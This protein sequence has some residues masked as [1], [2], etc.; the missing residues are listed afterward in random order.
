MRLFKVLVMLFMLSVSNAQ[1]NEVLTFLN[2]LNENQLSKT[3]L[4]FD[5]TSRETWHFLPGTMYKRHGIALYD[6]DETQKTHAFNLL[7]HHLSSTGYLKT[8]KIIELERYLGELSGNKVFRDP[9][10]YYFA[11]YGNPKKDSLWSWSFEGHHISLNFTVSNEK[12]SASPRFMGT[13]PAEIKEGPLKGQ[14]VLNKEEDLAFELINSM[15]E[16]QRAKTIF[17]SIA[18]PDI[19]TSNKSKVAPLEDEGIKAKNLNEKQKAILTKLIKEYLLTLPQELAKER[20]RAI[21]IAE[22]DDIRFAWAGS[23]DLTKGHYYRIQGDTF[24]IEFDNTQNNANHVHLV[25][26]EF[27]ADFGRDLIKEHY[28]KSDHHK[29]K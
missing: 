5:N 29:Q 7:K 14:R 9:E 27:N 13:N 19:L 3:I 2:T 16:E 15:G 22:F 24:L 4:S 23:T 10:K 20:Y 6:L 28:E 8:K 26:R 1:S 12:I 11:F 21:Q 17:K 25:W 18:F